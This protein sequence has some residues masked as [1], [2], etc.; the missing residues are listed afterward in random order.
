MKRER[1]F[2]D[3]SHLITLEKKK[4]VKHISNS[5]VTD[6]AAAVFTDYIL[7]V[8]KESFAKDLA[9]ARYYNVLSDGSTENAVIEQKLMCVSYLLKDVWL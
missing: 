2:T 4:H 9:N 1:P 8:T 3:Y 6:R 7:I 5:Y